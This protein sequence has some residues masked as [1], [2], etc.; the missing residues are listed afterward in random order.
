MTEMLV[1]VD[2]NDNQI[3]VEE[4]IK[5]HQPNGLLH[6][7]FTAL[8]FDSDGRLCL[9]KRSDVKMLWPRDWDGTFASHPRENESYV[10]SGVRRMLDEVGTKCTL[11]Y[12]NKFEY[13]VPYKNVGSENEICATLIGVLNDP[14]AINPKPE[15][16]SDVVW[17]T[18]DELCTL[19][20]KDVSSY[21]PWMIIALYFMQDSKNNILEKYSPLLQNWLDG[22]TRAIFLSAIKKH[23]AGNRWRILQ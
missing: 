17:V 5:C 14:L 22:K 13:H 23:M 21:C 10:D 19:L 16:I 18:A 6:R 20:L 12:M 7:A 15:E 2:E 11:D 9:C 3:G 8:L 4:K 1:R